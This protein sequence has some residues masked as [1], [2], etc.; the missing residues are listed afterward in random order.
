MLKVL[1]IE[2]NNIFL[3]HLHRHH[4]AKNV[5]EMNLLL[6][7]IKRVNS[8]EQEMNKAVNDSL[9]LLHRQNQLLNVMNLIVDDDHKRDESMN[10]VKVSS[11]PMTMKMI[12]L[13]EQ[14]QLEV[15]NDVLKTHVNSTN[16]KKQVNIVQVQYWITWN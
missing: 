6:M 14:N 15:M 16:E 4:V 11:W 1:T 8:V 7:M 12:F 2:Q 5:D 3:V 10:S 9:T 13:C